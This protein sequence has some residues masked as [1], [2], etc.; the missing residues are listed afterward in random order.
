MGT[1][2]NGDGL[3]LSIITSHGFNLSK[4]NSLLLLESSFSE[5]EFHASSADGLL[6]N[7]LLWSS[8]CMCNVAL[9]ALT[10]PSCEA[11]YNFISTTI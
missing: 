7:N 11:I 6:V 5:V 2:G 10:M 1:K 4:K 3:W 8:K 9:Q